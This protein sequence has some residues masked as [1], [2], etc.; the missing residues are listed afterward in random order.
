MTL[1][2]SKHHININLYIIQSPPVRQKDSGVEAV[3]YHVLST[4]QFLY[5]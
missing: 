2:Q 4:A 1:H 3:Y 5:M